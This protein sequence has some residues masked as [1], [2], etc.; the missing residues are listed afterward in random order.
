M[1]NDIRPIA[2]Q[3]GESEFPEWAKDLTKLRS[4]FAPTEDRVIIIPDPE[5]TKSVGGLIMTSSAKGKI[6]PLGEVVAVGPGRQ[7][8]Y[9]DFKIP[10]EIQ[11]GQRVQFAKFAGDDYFLDADGHWVD[12]ATVGRT[13]TG[14]ILIKV[15]RQSAILQAWPI[16]PLPQVPHA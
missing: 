8:E 7:S 14:T 4:L 5:K 9:A 11:V 6:E 16:Q 1:T 2:A 12:W 15:V 13:P 3:V 10:M